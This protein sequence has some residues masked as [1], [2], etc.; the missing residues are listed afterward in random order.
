[1]IWKLLYNRK[2]DHYD[3]QVPVSD[4]AISFLAPSQKRQV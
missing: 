4:Q 2:S 1:M 3:R